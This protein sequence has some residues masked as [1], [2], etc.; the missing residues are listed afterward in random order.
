MKKRL[1]ALWLISSSTF[2]GS[3]MDVGTIKGVF[4]KP[5]GTIAVSLQQGFPNAKTSGQCE[6]SNGWAGLG[7]SENIFKSAL[8]SA[9]ATQDT[10]KIVIEGCE[11]GW[12]RIK[13][14]YIE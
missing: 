1:L 8:L 4:V 7:T 2:A 6:N 14:L 12:Y 13:E 9:K 11:G 10:V 3:S 5:N